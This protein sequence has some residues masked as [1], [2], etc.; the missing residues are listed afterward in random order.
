VWAE[1]PIRRHADMTPVG[2]RAAANESGLT[3]WD[4]GHAPRGPRGTGNPPCGNRGNVFPTR[5]SD[6]GILWRGF[7]GWTARSAR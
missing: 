7:T 6:R 5:G 3:G 4:R 1:V 2:A